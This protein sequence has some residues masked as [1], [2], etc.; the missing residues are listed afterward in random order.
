[1]VDIGAARQHFQ[2]R[3]RRRQAQREAERQQWLQRVREAGLCFAGQF[4]GVQKVYVFGSLTQPGRFR[5]ASDIDMAVVC[6]SVEIESAFWRA[7]ERELERVVDVRPLTGAI[8]EAVANSGVK[9]YER[10]D[11]GIDQ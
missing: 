1:M 11:F 5:P 10:Q 9:I 7:V 2:K 8:A 3:E 4:P 6:D